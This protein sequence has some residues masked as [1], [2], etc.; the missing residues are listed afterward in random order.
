M[1]QN[2]RTIVQN[3]IAQPSSQLAALLAQFGSYRA[4]LNP[5]MPPALSGSLQLLIRIVARILLVVAGQ[6]HCPSTV[7]AG[8]HY[9]P[10]MQCGG[11]AAVWPQHAQHVIY[12][13]CT[14]F[15]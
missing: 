15:Y 2:Y 9:G 6:H 4:S 1:V 5:L 14:V 12:V 8:E 3:F 13:S 11:G 7:V 10:S